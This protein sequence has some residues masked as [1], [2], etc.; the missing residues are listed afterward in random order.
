MK[1]SRTPDRQEVV[2]KPLIAFKSKAQAD[3]KAVHIQ[4]YV[5]ILKKPAAQLLDVRRGFETASKVVRWL[6]R[7]FFH[8]V[9]TRLNKDRFS[10]GSSLNNGGC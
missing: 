6:E 4:E 1:F 10:G 8:L 2:S 7:P 9:V 3:E 5:S